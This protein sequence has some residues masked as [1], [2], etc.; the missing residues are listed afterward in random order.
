MT[1]LAMLDTG[2]LTDDLLAHLQTALGTGTTDPLVGDGV[3]PADVGWANG[4]PGSG[5][6]RPYVVLVDSGA[7]PRALSLQSPIPVWAT[8][9]SL[10]SFG[11]SRS[12][13]SWMATKAR[14]AV[15]GFVQHQFGSDPVWKVIGQEW[16]ALGG[17]TRVDATEPKG[18]QIFD[19]VSLLCDRST[20]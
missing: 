4:Q 3:A 6:F 19:T 18:W 20:S 14:R 5:V 2:A 10:R 16:S 9:W 13:V 15:A 12:Q 7:V 11:G 17:A 1:A 8:N